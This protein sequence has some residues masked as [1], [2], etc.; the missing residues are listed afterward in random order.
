MRRLKIGSDYK[1][2]LVVLSRRGTYVDACARLS[3]PARR[4]KAVASTVGCEEAA[5]ERG[6]SREG[7]ADDAGGQGLLEV[8][9]VVGRFSLRHRVYLLF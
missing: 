2:D 4:R 6:R 9:V 8:L 5:R 7:A 1:A 3:S